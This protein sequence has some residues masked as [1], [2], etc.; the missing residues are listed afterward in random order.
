MIGLNMQQVD[1]ILY[2]MGVLLRLPAPD[3]II[4]NSARPP[5]SNKKLEL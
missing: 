2:F 3:I 4:A 5:G 1:E